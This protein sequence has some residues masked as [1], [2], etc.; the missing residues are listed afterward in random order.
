MIRSKLWR[1][2]ADNLRSVL[3]SVDARTVELLD[4][5]CL[6]RGELLQDPIGRSEAQHAG[7]GSFT[8]SS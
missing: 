6:L 7:A 1:L 8:F 2:T 4:L 3:V 5:M